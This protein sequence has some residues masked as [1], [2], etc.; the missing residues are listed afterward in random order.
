MKKYI[1]IALILIFGTSI[2]SNYMTYKRFHSENKISE[3]TNTQ[4]ITQNLNNTIKNLTENKQEEIIVSNTTNNTE[5]KEL[6]KQTDKTAEAKSNKTSTSQKEI[7]QKNTI[8][9]VKK[10]S[11]ENKKNNK[12]NT[13][14]KTKEKSIQVQTETTISNEKQ[15]EQ[16]TVLEEE[17]KTNEEMVNK[18]REVIKNN[19]SDYMKEYGY[20]IVVDSSIKEQTN[21]FTFTEN[22]VKAMVTYK[23]G[24][25]RIYAEDYYYK[26]QLV[27]TECYI[28]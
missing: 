17:Y 20:E 8:D 6:N 4:S 1:F 22:R 25:I 9:E 27:M 24:T 28:Y 13:P 23:F 15:K 21:Q 2:S 14:Q 10:E 18:I 7:A 11:T 3:N 12:N 16:S 19:E 5:K 26:G